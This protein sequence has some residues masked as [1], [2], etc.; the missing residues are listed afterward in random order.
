M[1][2][3]IYGLY[4]FIHAFSNVCVHIYAYIHVL[5]YT[6]IFFCW[7]LVIRLL[8]PSSSFQP[9]QMCVNLVLSIL[10]YLYLVKIKTKTKI[11]KEINDHEG[12][13]N[14]HENSHKL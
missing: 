3:F 10:K 12:H 14:Q 7:F 1:F 9:N 13:P 5:Y 2:P 4:A 11:N 6:Y 8:K